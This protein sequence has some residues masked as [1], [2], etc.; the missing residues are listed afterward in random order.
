MVINVIY[1]TSSGIRTDILSASA[2]RLPFITLHATLCVNS[3][4]IDISL[5]VYSI[6]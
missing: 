6:F 1:G 4:I 2:S 5:A 3:F